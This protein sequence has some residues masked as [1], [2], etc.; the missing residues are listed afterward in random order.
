MTYKEQREAGHEMVEGFGTERTAAEWAG[1]LDMRLSLFLYCTKTEG[2]TV[3]RLYEFRGLKYKPPKKR[4]P[5]ESEAMLRTKERMRILLTMSGYSDDKTL[6]SIEVRRVGN[7]GTHAISCM[8]ELLGLYAYRSGRLKLSGGQGL[9]LFELEWEDARIRQNKDGLWEPHPDTS[10]LLIRRALP[11]TGEISQSEYDFIIAEHTK[12][13][14]VTYDGF[15]KRYTCA[16][17]ASIL[18]VPKSTLWRHLKRGQTIE[19]FAAERGIRRT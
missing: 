8:G 10:A 16:T 7:N 13:G 17:W 6:D 1:L 15:G 9:P 12:A 18:R 2:M 3:E 11:T 14:R 19:E 5:R 4:K